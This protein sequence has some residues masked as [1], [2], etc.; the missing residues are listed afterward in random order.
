MPEIHD[1]RPDNIAG[2][3]PHY[4]CD[5]PGTILRLL[6]CPMCTQCPSGQYLHDGSSSSVICNVTQAYTA[7]LTVCTMCPAGKYQNMTGQLSCVNCPQNF[8]GSA[9]GSS[10]SNCSG[11]CPPATQCPGGCSSATPILPGVI[12]T[13]Q[14][15]TTS[16]EFK[17]NQCW[18]AGSLPCW[19]VCSK[20]R[21][22]LLPS[23]FTWTIP[24]L[25]GAGFVQ[26]LASSQR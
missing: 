23:L 21:L 13:L 4:F 14:N 8:F 18:Y 2:G 3:T 1:N 11:L 17:S 12:Y 19:E 10:S 22:L 15:D 7:P 6:S 26:G 20:Q 24:G 16:C 25:P 9:Q 5:E